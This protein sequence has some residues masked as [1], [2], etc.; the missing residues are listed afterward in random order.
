MKCSLMVYLAKNMYTGET[1]FFCRLCVSLS[2]L[3]I[4][5]P[6]LRVFVNLWVSLTTLNIFLPSLRVFVRLCMS[7]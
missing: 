3:N 5:L 6:S 1:N 4:V 7:L 2:T